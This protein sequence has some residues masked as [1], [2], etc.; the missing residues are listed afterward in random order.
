MQIA[1]TGSRGVI[2]TVLTS[3]LRGFNITP[4][5]TPDV[6]VRNYDQLLNHLKGKDAVIHLAKSRDTVPE[7]LRSDDDWLM[8]SNV[9]RAALESKVKRVIVASSVHAD[10]FYAWKGPGKLSADTVPAPTTPYGVNKVRIEALGRYYS[11]KGLEVVCVRFG[12]VNPANKPPEDNYWEDAVWLSH[13]D[14]VAMMKACITAEKV[15]HN[16]SV[17]YA[18]SNNKNRIHDISNPFNWKP[19]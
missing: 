10:N 5:N 4:L 12:G 7:N 9:Y 2:G 3:G 11:T 19:V 13:E 1:I 16:F 18:V 17:C 15:P 8:A 6:D 14:C